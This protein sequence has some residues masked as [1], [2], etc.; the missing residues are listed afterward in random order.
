MAFLQ[1]ILGTALHVKKQELIGLVKASF[2][3]TAVSR[4]SMAVGCV[5]C[6]F[7]A[8]FSVS[9]MGALADLSLCLLC[10]TLRKLMFLMWTE[11][12]WGDIVSVTTAM[13]TLHIIQLLIR[14]QFYFF[15]KDAHLLI[16]L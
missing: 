13:V 15:Y 11:L 6:E 9:K 5:G 3:F 10:E 4:C 7:G 2:C 8:S 1:T 14:P 16:I 12:R